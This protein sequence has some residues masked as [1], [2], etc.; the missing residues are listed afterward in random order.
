[1]KLKQEKEF[2]TRTKTSYELGKERIS[3]EQEVYEMD[4][5]ISKPTMPTRK[6]ILEEGMGGVFL[7]KKE[8]QE[9]GIKTS[10]QEGGKK[11]ASQKII[12]YA[13]YITGQKPRTSGT[14]YIT[15]DK[16]GRPLYSGLW[17][18]ICWS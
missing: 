6:E 7:T 16:K 13:E 3:Y 5:E 17:K 18:S 2:Q 9:M 1:M 14:G 8:M 11:S 15:L 10:T 12:E 4:K